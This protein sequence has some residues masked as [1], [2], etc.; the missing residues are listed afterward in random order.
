MPKLPQ[1]KIIRNFGSET[2]QP[3]RRPTQSS[4][5][6]AHSMIKSLNDQMAKSIPPNSSEGHFTERSQFT[7]LDYQT[8]RDEP[9]AFFL[10]ASCDSAAIIPL[11]LPPE[12]LILSAPPAIGPRQEI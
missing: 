10:R 3:E 8:A 7:Y 6:P 4:P 12:M 9:V 2:G 11:D 5:A 1:T